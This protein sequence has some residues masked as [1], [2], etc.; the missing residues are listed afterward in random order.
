ME[1]QTVVTCN[2]C[3]FIQ[4]VYYYVFECTFVSPSLVSVGGLLSG[5]QFSFKLNCWYICLL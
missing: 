4:S 1:I 5:T 2:L 3:K